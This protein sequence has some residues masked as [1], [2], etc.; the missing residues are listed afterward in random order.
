MTASFVD[1]LDAFLA[2]DKSALSVGG[3]YFN[4]DFLAAVR[5][6]IDSVTLQK[7]VDP[8]LVGWAHLPHCAMANPGCRLGVA[9]CVS[10]KPRQTLHPM[11]STS[12][13]KLDATANGKKSTITD[14]ELDTFFAEMCDT[15]KH[16][17]VW[18]EKT[19]PTELPA[20]TEPLG[21]PTIDINRSQIRSQKA[22][23]VKALC[24][25]TNP[26][27]LRQAAWDSPGYKPQETYA[28]NR[29]S[30]RCVSRGGE[31]SIGPVF[32][33]QSAEQLNQIPPWLYPF[34]ARPCPK[35]PRHG[36]VDSRL[37][38]NVSA[39]EHLF[40][41][42]QEADPDAEMLMMFPCEGRFSAVLN[43]QGVTYGQSNNGV[44]AG[45]HGNTEIPARASRD[46]L[47]TSVGYALSTVMRPSDIDDAPEAYIEAVQDKH[48]IK[49]VQ[50]RGGPK[51]G[52]QSKW[53]IHHESPKPYLL[54]IS[55]ENVDYD[56]MAHIKADADPSTE[57][58]LDALIKK[59]GDNLLM[60]TDGVSEN[61]HIVV[62]AIVRNV[63][64]CF[65]TANEYYNLSSPK[66]TTALNGVPDDAISVQKHET[67]RHSLGKTLK[68]RIYSGPVKAMS[69]NKS[70][71]T[72]LAEWCALGLGSL[73]AQPSW[74]RCYTITDDDNLY[75][76]GHLAAEGIAA[77]IWLPLIACIG[78]ARHAD[79]YHGSASMRTEVYASMSRCSN[80]TSR[81]NLFNIASHYTFESF[82]N[83][84]IDAVH[85][86][87]LPGWS[88]SYGG[89][90]WA[91]SGVKALKLYQVAMDFVSGSATYEALLSAWND[92]AMAAHNNGPLV[93]KFL[94]ME[95]VNA[96]SAAPG[97][98]LT[99]NAVGEAFYSYSQRGL[100]GKQLDE[101]QTLYSRINDDPID[102][103]PSRR[104][105]NEARCKNDS[106][107]DD[108]RG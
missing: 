21:F 104:Y 98:G 26:V 71:E 99:T 33:I 23:G 58:H 18:A 48:R 3:V 59:Y 24:N 9:R 36:F 79:S 51:A 105:R 10:A 39:A 43:S 35:T 28:F 56:G 6:D 2:S 85:D 78:E 25:Y 55:C 97:I 1:R 44:T 57:A 88:R 84:A 100:Y 41:M 7:M 5:R 15:H 107:R 42:A 12:L 16:C 76:L 37:V 72:F 46:E 103:G 60:V 38:E 68:G 102:L 74:A 8:R 83:L 96:I 82:F 81:D 91:K 20:M 13:P 64:I 73:H 53:L 87:A 86:L 50:V 11:R 19:K 52:R 62:Q 75:K 70:T 92:A 106:I 4:R 14:Q 29:S 61:S 31:S 65:M 22:R 66:I 17:P 27:N 45:Y 95:V 40:I 34:F 47:L 89:Y 93:T 69:K 101:M 54:R 77:M 90:N 94:P 63:N 67:Y 80:K 30:L 49:L 108:Y 32:L